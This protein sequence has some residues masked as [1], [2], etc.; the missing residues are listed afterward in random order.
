MLA[1]YMA[2][3]ESVDRAELMKLFGEKY[4]VPD[5]ETLSERY[6]AGKISDDLSRVRDKDNR[7]EIL[8]VQDKDGIKYVFIAKCTNLPI[9]KSIKR[10]IKGDIEGQSASLEKVELQIRAVEKSLDAKGD[11]DGA[12][13]D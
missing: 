7:R 10:R 12:D 13:G 1:D 8:A 5:Y 3:K 9:L 6:I 11:G 2:G 4:I